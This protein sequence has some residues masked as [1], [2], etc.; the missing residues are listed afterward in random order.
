MLSWSINSIAQGLNIPRQAKK[1]LKESTNWKKSK[2]LSTINSNERSYF[3]AF[4][5]RDK[6]PNGNSLSAAIT[7]FQTTNKNI[8]SRKIISSLEEALQIQKWDEKKSWGDVEVYGIYLKQLRRYVRI[9]TR[10]KN[11]VTQYSTASFRKLFF[12]ESSVETEVIQKVLFGLLKKKPN[13]FVLNE[14]FKK[15]FIS[16]ATAFENFAPY[17]PYEVF[18]QL[19]EIGPKVQEA[20]EQVTLVSKFIQSEGSNIQNAISGIEQFAKEDAVRIADGI[21]NISN[22]FSNPKKLFLSSA[23]VALGGITVSTIGSGI[24]ELGEFL[25]DLITGDMERQQLIKKFQEE[26]EKWEKNQENFNKLT[27]ILDDTLTL[28]KNTEKLKISKLDFIELEKVQEGTKIQIELSRKDLMSYYKD[29]KSE[30][31]NDELEKITKLKT[32]SIAIAG[33]IQIG[34]TKNDFKSPVCNKLYEIFTKLQKVDA[35]LQASRSQ[36]IYPELIEAWQSLWGESELNQKLDLGKVNNKGFK[37]IYD[38]RVEHLKQRYL[39]DSE[40][41]R[42]DFDSKI[43]KCASKRYYQICAENPQNLASF[44]R[45]KDQEWLCKNSNFKNEHAWNHMEKV[46]LKKYKRNYQNHCKKNDQTQRYEWAHEASNSDSK[47]YFY[48]K[49]LIK[50]SYQKAKS[51][52]KAH[53][54]E[55]IKLVES[56]FIRT[57]D[58]TTDKAYN[59][60]RQWFQKLL[61]TQK[62]I[63]ALAEKRAQQGNDLQKLC[64]PKKNH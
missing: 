10:T 27:K 46:C 1:I 2:D 40:S 26:K 11:G 8:T 13:K 58:E 51:D 56:S 3:R 48:Q 63:L 15:L 60:N 45:K 42:V 35:E 52:A 23:S 19:S 62:K 31:I 21:T 5:K 25:L 50:I 20:S 53:Y 9:Y 6:N 41:L 38:K 54:K 55:E 16:S 39:M 57:N 12:V 64:F 37:K 61:K 47:N 32:K 30:C 49:C 28:L 4:L 36:L 24:G 7:Y 18:T 33:L 29:K 14:I 59:L 17:N 43:S 34:K 22:L 44:M